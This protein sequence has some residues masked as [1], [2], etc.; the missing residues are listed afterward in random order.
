MKPRAE[1]EPAN[2]EEIADEQLVDRVLQ[3]DV[4]AYDPLVLRYQTRLY[5]VIYNMTSNHEDTNDLLMVVFDRAFRNLSSYKRTASFSTWIHRI[6][7]NQTLNFIKSRKRQGF[8]LSLNDIENN[9]DPELDAELSKIGI[10]TGPEREVRLGELQ[11]KLNESLQKLSEDHRTV[12][13]LSDIEGVP[14]VEIARILN[15]SEGTVRSRLHYAHQQLRKMLGNY[16]K[17]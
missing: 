15:L 17:D 14:Q 4:T 13:V 8:N 10:P 16:L 1:G 7:I 12:V 6:A 11:K 9:L 2:P 3:G 5:S